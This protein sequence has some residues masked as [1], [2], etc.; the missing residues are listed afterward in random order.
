MDPTTRRIA[1]ETWQR[2]SDAISNG[3]TEGAEFD[4]WWDRL[5]G[6]LQGGM[7]GPRTWKRLKE[8]AG[9]VSGG[10]DL[11]G[12]TAAASTEDIDPRTYEEDDGVCIDLMK[13]VW[14]PSPTLCTLVSDKHGSLRV[15]H[16]AVVGGYSNKGRR[17]V[18]SREV[19]TTPSGLIS[20]AFSG[21]GLEYHTSGGAVRALR[22]RALRKKDDWPDHFALHH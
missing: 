5:A 8:V 12:G 14:G 19:L 21:E 3:E 18:W 11:E 20:L 13:K 10:M 4:V 2:A 15:Q 9:N 22:N 6:L 1:A 16:R 7:V 17:G